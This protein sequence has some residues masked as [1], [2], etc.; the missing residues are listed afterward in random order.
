MSDIYQ[1]KNGLG[2]VGSYQVSGIPFASSS[3]ACTSGSI[4][5]ID[6]PKVTRFVCVRCDSGSLDVGFSEN[7]MSNGNY[8]S[9]ATSES[10]TGDW[11]IV[12]LYLGGDAE[13]TVIAGMANIEAE[14]LND[15]W[16]G[17]VGVG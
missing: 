13:A 17:T 5:E 7:G 12:R 11:R 10:F 9:L 14:M 3:I 8:F 4:T 2:N 1:P 15:N 16:S 6:F